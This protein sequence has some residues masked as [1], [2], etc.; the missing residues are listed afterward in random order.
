MRWPENDESQT[1]GEKVRASRIPELL[2]TVYS[3]EQS[4]KKLH[5]INR[6]LVTHL[7]RAA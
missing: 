5:L 2:D 4:V 3:Q 1:V 6:R 7:D